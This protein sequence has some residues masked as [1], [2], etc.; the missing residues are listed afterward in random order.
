M[1]K[2]VSRGIYAVAAAAF[3]LGAPPSL[4]DEFPVVVAKILQSQT[5]SRIAS[6]DAARKQEMINCVN[7][8]VAKIPAGKKRFVLAGATFD[9]QQDRFGT[10]VQENRAEWEQKIAAGCSSIV[11]RR[12]GIGHQ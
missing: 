5:D 8:V 7:G 6:L 10:V 1:I 2:Q 3:L 9:E 12:G 11:V 4:A